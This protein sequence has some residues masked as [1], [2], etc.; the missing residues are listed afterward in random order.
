MSE[1]ADENAHG[2]KTLFAPLA[3]MFAA[4]CVICVLVYLALAAP[5]QWFTDAPTVAWSAR[6]LQIAKG[7]GRVVADALFVAP[8]DASQVVVVSVKTSFAAK[9]YPA[10]Q[11]NAAEVPDDADVS[12]LWRSDKAPEKLNTL[13]LT[14]V[15]GR[16]MGVLTSEHPQWT[17][18]IEGLALAMHGSIAEPVRILGGAAKTLSLRETLADR[19]R[20][21]FVFEPWSGAS[22][23]TIHGGAYSQNLPLPMLLAASI[24]LA[25]LGVIAMRRYRKMTIGVLPALAVYSA[26][27]WLLL[28]A[29]W[30]LNLVRQVGAT[31]TTFAGKS[32]AEQRAVADD[33]ALF[34]FTTKAKAT[35]P[36][37]PVRVIVAADS[38]YLRGR[39]AYHLYPHNAFGPRGNTL[40]DPT[41]VRAGD[42]V[43]VVGRKGVQFDAARGLLRWD[44]KEPV[45]AE[46]KLSSPGL[47]LFVLR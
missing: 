42:W 7:A 43:A 18:R 9:D 15:A 28:D 16:L 20:E 21:W 23:N 47:A 4:A 41:Q 39:A 6:D 24:A 22:I 1:I 38:P 8:N 44:N 45:S 10:I 29:K 27:A 25:T 19:V 12:L 26:L 32:W 5:K 3:M 40:P 36:D 17:G 30:T 37:A 46:L 14:V 33:G 34:D 2:K 13:P 35:M 31:S 11:W